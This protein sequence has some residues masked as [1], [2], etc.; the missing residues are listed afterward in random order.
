MFGTNSTKKGDVC[1]V[2]DRTEY[3]ARTERQE[4]DRTANRKKIATRRKAKYM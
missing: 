4:P 1:R 2:E 3:I